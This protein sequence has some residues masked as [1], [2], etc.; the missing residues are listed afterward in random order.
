MVYRGRG[1]PAVV[2]FGNSTTCWQERV[3]GQDLWQRESLVL[4]N[5]SIGAGLQYCFAQSSGYLSWHARPELPN[6]NRIKMDLSVPWYRRAWNMVCPCSVFSSADQKLLSE[7]TKKCLSLS[8]LLT[9]H[10]LYTQLLLFWFQLFRS[11]DKIDEDDALVLYI[12]NC[13]PISNHMAILPWN[14]N[15]KFKK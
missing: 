15:L 2:R 3:E 10:K 9:L 7:D 13:P 12:L 4:L 1:F 5:H 11:A 8:S 6:R 14:L